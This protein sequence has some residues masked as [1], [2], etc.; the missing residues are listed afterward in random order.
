LGLLPEFESVGSWKFNSVA[1]L[2]SVFEAVWRQPE[3]AEEG[4]DEGKLRD[5]K[6]I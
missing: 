5:G 2:L 4:V 3:G 1:R 6:N